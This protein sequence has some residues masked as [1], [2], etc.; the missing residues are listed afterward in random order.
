MDTS[1]ITGYLFYLLTG[2][3]GIIFLSSV[4]IIGEQTDY[5]NRL[6][7]MNKNKSID[8][9]INFKTMPNSQIKFSK[10]LSN[11]PNL[12]YQNPTKGVFFFDIKNKKL[13]NNIEKIVRKIQSM[14][15]NVEVF[16]NNKKILQSWKIGNSKVDFDNNVHLIDS[17][18]I[19]FTNK[20]FDQFVGFQL[21]MKTEVS[22]KKIRARGSDKGENDA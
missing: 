1:K 13:K 10:F 16:S 14:D 8:Y 9:F 21:I 12:I 6:A 19:C 2:I 4:V 17:P 3:V 18:Y 22:D 15:V 5:L 11:F 7:V 20:C